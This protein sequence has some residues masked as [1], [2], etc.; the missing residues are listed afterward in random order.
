M[1]GLPKQVVLMNRVGAYFPGQLPLSPERIALLNSLGAYF[2]GQTPMPHHKIVEPP[3]PSTKAYCASPRSRPL[4]RNRKKRILEAVVPIVRDMPAGT[5]FFPID[6]AKQLG[7][8]TRV[9]AH[10]LRQ[11][12]GVEHLGNVRHPKLNVPLTC[13]RRKRETVK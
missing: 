13:F 12:E 9:V 7:E 1:K 11:V 10:L 3:P 6:I 2:P 4:L 5:K 8:P